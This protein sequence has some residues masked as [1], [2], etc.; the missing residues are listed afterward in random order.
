MNNQ[1]KP[2]ALDNYLPRLSRELQQ[3]WAERPTDLPGVK[4]EFI[5]PRTGIR[6]TVEIRGFTDERANYQP[7]DDGC[8][9]Q[10]DGVM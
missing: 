8:P 7:A 1:P 3:L 6:Y 5:E 9:D 2:D 10:F 4:W